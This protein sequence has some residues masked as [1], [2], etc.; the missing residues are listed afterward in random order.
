MEYYLKNGYIYKTVEIDSNVVNE[1]QYP[2]SVLGPLNVGSANLKKMYTLKLELSETDQTKYPDLKDKLDEVNADFDKVLKSYKGYT[3]EEILNNH[4]E[5][6]EE[7]LRKYSFTVVRKNTATPVNISTD[8]ISKH[9][10]LVLTITNS[11]DDV[12]S[13]LAKLEAGGFT[14]TSTI[15]A[16]G[17]DIKE[18][19]V[20]SSG[21]NLFTATT[22]PTNPTEMNDSI[23]N[24]IKTLQGLDESFSKFECQDDVYSFYDKDTGEKYV[25]IKVESEEV[26]E[27]VYFEKDATTGKVITYTNTIE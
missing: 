9:E 15:R 12:K 27:I 20:V 26:T 14:I 11:Y 16:F 22:K 2:S 13:A 6:K 10:T 4:A 8:V 17:R 24:M 23:W 18:E 19:F 25:T 1:I 5:L 7:L 21:T 3:V